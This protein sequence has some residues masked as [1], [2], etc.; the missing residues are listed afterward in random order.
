M[1]KEKVKSKNIMLKRL[2]NFD[3]EHQFKPSFLKE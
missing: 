2:M 3:I 1:K